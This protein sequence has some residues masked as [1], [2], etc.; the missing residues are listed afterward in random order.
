ML[1]YIDMNQPNL[2]KDKK[3]QAPIPPVI[4]KE[5]RGGHTHK[6]HLSLRGLELE[7]RK[8]SHCLLGT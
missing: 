8:Y 3:S 7:S 6:T 1:S 2:Y 4:A 5:A